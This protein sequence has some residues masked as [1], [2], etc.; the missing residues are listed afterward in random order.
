MIDLQVMQVAFHNVIGDEMLYL[1]PMLNMAQQ[2]SH[3]AS[4]YWLKQMPALHRYTLQVEQLKLVST[5]NPRVV[6]LCWCE[7]KPDPWVAVHNVIGDDVLYLQLFNCRWHLLWTYI[8]SVVQVVN[9][10]E[11]DCLEG[12]EVSV[13]RQRTFEDAPKEVFP[14]TPHACI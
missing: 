5:Y 1:Q 9:R 13:G 10:L 12:E 14:P 3:H 11:I 4:W 8:I 2:I 7:H 6:L